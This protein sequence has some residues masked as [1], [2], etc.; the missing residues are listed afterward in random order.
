M[1]KPQ[2]SCLGKAA[3]CIFGG[4][5]YQLLYFDRLCNYNAGLA[6]KAIQSEMANYGN[7]LCNMAVAL[8]LVVVLRLFGIVV[9]LVV[10]KSE[11]IC[12]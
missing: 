3:V 12:A 2:L 7:G 4:L 8:L 9:F 11:R 10:V 6:T 5:V 1:H